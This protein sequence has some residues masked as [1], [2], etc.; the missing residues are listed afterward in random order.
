VG[1]QIR[2]AIVGFDEAETLGLVEPLHGACGHF[3]VTP[4]NTGCARGAQAMVL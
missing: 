3:N 2:P 1:E 4:L